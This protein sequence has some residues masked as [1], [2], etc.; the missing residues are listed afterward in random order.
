MLTLLGSNMYFPSQAIDMTT[1]A[2]IDINSNSVES[3][4]LSLFVV[5]GG[6]EMD[7]VSYSLKHRSVIR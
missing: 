7:S 1:V 5:V 2:I 3:E 4:F 6:G